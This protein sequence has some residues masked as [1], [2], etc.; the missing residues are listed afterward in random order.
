VLGARFSLADI[1]IAVMSR[2]MGGRSWTPANCP[3]IEA[4]HQA[5]AARPAIAPIW[6]AH[7]L[8]AA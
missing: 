3:R 7:R 8:G 6:Q 4:L 5:V 1:P 2:W